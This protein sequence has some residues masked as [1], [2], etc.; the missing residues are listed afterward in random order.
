MIIPIKA[1]KICDLIKREDDLLVSVD[2]IKRIA[3]NEREKA[4]QKI[5][6]EIDNLNSQGGGVDDLKFFL[7]QLKEQS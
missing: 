1:L 3:K 7:E 6:N 4:I 2:D 5:S